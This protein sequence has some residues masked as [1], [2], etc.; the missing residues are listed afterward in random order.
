MQCCPSNISMLLLL[1]QVVQAPSIDPVV[2][3]AAAAAIWGVLLLSR[4]LR[5]RTFCAFFVLPPPDAS[6]SKLLAAALSFS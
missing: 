1:M 2:G 4:A 6:S 3:F 5:P